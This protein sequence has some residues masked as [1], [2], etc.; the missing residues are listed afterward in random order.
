MDETVLKYVRSFFKEKDQSTKLLCLT[1]N[2]SE[3]Q[4]NFPTMQIGVFKYN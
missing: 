3:T 2:H 4:E 1:C